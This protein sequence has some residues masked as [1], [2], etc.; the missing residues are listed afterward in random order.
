MKHQEKNPATKLPAAEP[1]DLLD[2]ALTAMRSELPDSETMSAAGDRA[3]QRVSQEAS[4][5]V[6]AG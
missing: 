1:G 6:R 3:W 5:A 4:A 2:R